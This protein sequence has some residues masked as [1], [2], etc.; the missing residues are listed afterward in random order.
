MT[1]PIVQ[2]FYEAMEIPVI[3]APLFI[4]A[5]PRLIIQQCQSGIIGAMPALNARSTEELDSVLAEITDTLA[6]STTPKVSPYAINQIVHHSNARL[7]KDIALC[8]KYKTP[9]LITSLSAPSD[10]AKAVHQWGGLVFHD[11]ISIRHAEKALEAGVDGLIL[12]CNGAGGHAGTLNPF[13]LLSEVRQFYQGPIALSGAIS[14]GAGILGARAAGAD[15]AYIGTR[16]IATTEANANSDYKNMLIAANA[17]DIVY[18]PYFT[19][20]AGNYL[21]QSILNAGIQPEELS[22]GDKSKMNF[23]EKAQNT[24]VWKDIWGAGQGVGCIHSILP[25]SQLVQQLKREYEAAK[26]ALLLGI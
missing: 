4:I 15:F 14:T 24:K 20:V 2:K 16:F 1:H 8:E 7:D 17:K 12:V 11:V 25:T 26:K 21:A 19:G 9:L 5:N 10:I 22:K 13:A 23:S 18:T 3:G 6:A